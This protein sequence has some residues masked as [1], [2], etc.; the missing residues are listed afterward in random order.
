[1][2]EQLAVKGIISKILPE[3]SGKTKDRKDWKKVE[4]LLKTESEYNNLYCFEIFGAEKVDE[5]LKFKKEG[6][7]VDVKFNVNCREH[8]GRYYTSLSAWSVFS[9]KQEERK[10][11]KK[12]VEETIEDDGDLPF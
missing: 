9:E 4:F 11:S 12:K 3:V 8:Q 7:T 5:F 2:S 10:T 6:T 1:M